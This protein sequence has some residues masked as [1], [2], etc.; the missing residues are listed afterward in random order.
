MEEEL[1]WR[2]GEF[3]VWNIVLIEIWR[4]CYIV[5]LYLF[6]VMLL[7]QIMWQFVIGMSLND[8]QQ[9]EVCIL[10]KYVVCKYIYE[11]KLV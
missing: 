8:Y 2:V 9:R 10:I 7:D 11:K 5:E 6:G 4:E 3:V 1:W